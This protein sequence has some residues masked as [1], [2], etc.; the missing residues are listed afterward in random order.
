MSSQLPGAA[1]MDGGSSKLAAAAPFEIDHV[2]GPTGPTG[3][4]TPFADS[5]SCGYPPGPCELGQFSSVSCASA[6]RCEA[7]GGALAEGE[8][9]GFGFSGVPLAEGWDGTSWTIQPIPT[10]GSPYSAFDAVSCAATTACLAVG[11]FSGDGPSGPFAE[12]WNGSNWT[13]RPPPS[14]SGAT[15]VTFDYVQCASAGSCMVVGSYQDSSGDLLPLADLWNGANHWSTSTSPSLPTGGTDGALYGVSCPAVNACTA[16]G[17]YS[18]RA[19]SK[20]PLAEAW[21]GSSWAPTTQQ[22]GLPASART[23]L[24]S[25]VWC[26]SGSSCTAVGTSY[27]AGGGGS[28][29]LA[30]GWNGTAWTIQT[31]NNPSGS[32]NNSFANLSCN[33]SASGAP[34]APCQAVGSTAFGPLV[35]SFDGTNW[36]MPE[37]ANSPPDSTLSDVSCTSATACTA[38]GSYTDSTFGATYTLAER[39]NGT[40]WPQEATPDAALFAVGNATNV[41]STTATLTGT[42][43][44]EGANVTS[45]YFEYGTTTSYGS[46]AQC[47]QPVGGG[48]SA[49][50]VSADMSE[51]APNT[52]YY[53]DL[54]AANAAGGADGGAS[55]CYACRSGSSFTTSPSGAPTVATGSAA[56]VTSSSAT[57]TGS[58]N[59]NGLALTGCYFEYGATT[60]YGEQAHCAETVGPGSTPVAVT[61]QVSGLTPGT[62][63]HLRLV[64]TNGDGTG[65]GEDA[66]FTTPG[67]LACTASDGLPTIC[68]VTP[69]HGPW[70]GGAQVSVN[71]WNFAAGDRLCLY[72]GVPSVSFGPDVCASQTNVVSPT[73]ITA[74]MPATHIIDNGQRVLGV[75]SCCVQNNVSSVTY[76]LSPPALAP[77]GLLLGYLGKGG[78]Q[79]SG[80]VVTSPTRSIIV[81]AGHCVWTGSQ[82]L[83][84]FTFE[85]GSTKN[86]AAPYGTWTATGSDVAAT[87]LNYLFTGNPSY[88]Y[89]FVVFPHSQRGALEDVVG[90]FPIAFDPGRAQ[91]WTTYGYPSG[92]LAQ[93]TG[94][95]SEDEFTFSGPSQMVMPACHLGEGSSGGPWINAQNGF[96]FGIGAVNSQNLTSC[97]INPI[98]CH[99]GQ[100]GTYLGADAKTVFSEIQVLANAVLMPIIQASRGGTSVVVAKATNPPTL[101][102][103]GTLI[104]SPRAADAAESRGRRRAKRLVLGTVSL[105][106]PRHRQ[107]AVR[108]SLTKAGRAR[109]RHDRRI[110]GTLVLRITSS[111]G[112]HYTLH[113]AVTVARRAR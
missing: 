63:Y 96:T 110:S 106:V 67:P 44:P 36:S 100:T 12:S 103:R 89:G 75:Q 16:V 69:N 86:D 21:N 29:T 26:W 90:G 93:C 91:G 73:Q 39:W 88:D 80:T 27:N 31:T 77:V 23:A 43:Y 62:S 72:T 64:A 112:R 94:A 61:A 1:P 97:P 87:D 49:V 5:Y 82:Y 60:A 57:V 32:N 83:G 14:P 28:L 8:F 18:I 79:C 22:P 65:S 41:A 25:A 15:N 6:V 99:T 3:Y 51:L 47:A 92:T 7:V 11:N 17:E 42:V 2:V 4:A 107:V 109:L 104:S 108:V 13:I 53:F 24:L 9:S 84:S 70:W 81:T 66:T 46:V 74:V 38:V 19:T 102:I 20:L 98:G 34:G 58:V 101:A 50:A 48:N 45:C 111:K 59:P 85:P 56:N 52:T 105:R 35:E 71:G 30:E 95:S 37:S 68:S 113:E 33:P 76:S 40:G 78:R 10:P 54:V 55:G